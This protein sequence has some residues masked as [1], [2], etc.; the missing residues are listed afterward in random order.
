[1]R[2]GNGSRLH[3]FSSS[4]SAPRPG[5]RRTRAACAYDGL[6]SRQT[7]MKARTAGGGAHFRRVAQQSGDG[8]NALNGTQAKR[9]LKIRV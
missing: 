7:W 6:R 2:P 1:M 5:E 9:L 3:P 4:L 8:S